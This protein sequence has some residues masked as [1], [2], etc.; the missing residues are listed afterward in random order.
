MIYMQ[1]FY[2]TC[3]FGDNFFL[4]YRVWLILG[5]FQTKN[6]FKNFI[7]EIFRKIFTDKFGEFCKEIRQVFFKNS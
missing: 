3:V 1:Y 7:G 4:H 5:K 2:Q 6:F